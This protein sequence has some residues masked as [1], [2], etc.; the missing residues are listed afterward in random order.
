MSLAALR[1]AL[2]DHGGTLAASLRPDPP[3]ASIAAPGAETG[4]G[5]PQLAAAGPRASGRER[6]Y[7]L[8]LE[9]ILEGSLL[10]YGAARVVRGADPDL[11]L[12]LGDRA[13]RPGPG[14]A[15]RARRPRRGG[16]AG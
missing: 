2:L 14:P 12:L 16:R 10:H 5:A 13:L 11:A 3:S 4:A 9:M 1:E 15:G 6:D 8:L 7:E